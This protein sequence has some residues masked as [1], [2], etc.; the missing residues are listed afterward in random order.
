MKPLLLTTI[1]VFSTLLVACGGKTTI[2]TTTPSE[3]TNEC[4][5]KKEVCGEATNFQLEYSKMT[6]EQQKDMTAV[7][8][9]YTEQ[10]ERARKM[11]KDSRK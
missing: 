3:E 7:L 1:T 6:K 9:S 10:C 5:Y 8:N 2:T 11:C 4:Y